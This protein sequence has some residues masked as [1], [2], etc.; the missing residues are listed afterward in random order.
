[1]DD[2]VEY[3]DLVAGEEADKSDATDALEDFFLADFFRF[4]EFDNGGDVGTSSSNTGKGVFLSL[5]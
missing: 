5:T 1:M 4:C 2:L 3:L